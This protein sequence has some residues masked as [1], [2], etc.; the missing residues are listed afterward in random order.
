MAA[1]SADRHAEATAALQRLIKEVPDVFAAQI[2]MAAAWQ[3]NRD[4][5]LHWLD[6]ALDLHD[7]GLLDI[8][9][10]PQFD[11]LRGDPRFEAALQRMH[12]PGSVQAPDSA[13]S[14]TPRTG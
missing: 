3:G 11:P 12:L 14:A 2:A 6:H 5:A 7:A 8:R 9:T 10:T 4:L 1:W 13:G